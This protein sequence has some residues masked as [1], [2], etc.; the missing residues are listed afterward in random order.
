MGE[1]GECVGY[2]RRNEINYILLVYKMS[3]ATILG[4]LMCK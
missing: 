2:R 4:A 3:E 1:S